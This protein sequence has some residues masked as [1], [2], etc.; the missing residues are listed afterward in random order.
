MVLQD[1]EQVPEFQDPVQGLVQRSA[2]HTAAVRAGLVQQG[3]ESVPEV[4]AVQKDQAQ[5]L[6]RRR[7][8]QKCPQVLRISCLQVCHHADQPGLR[9]LPVILEFLVKEHEGR[10]MGRLFIRR[11][12]SPL[13]ELKGHFRLERKTVPE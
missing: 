1:L 9:G 5:P 8:L 3:D 11:L 2:D 4:C 7:L 10:F 13:E 12:K 6:V